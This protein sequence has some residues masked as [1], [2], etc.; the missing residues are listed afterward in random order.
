MEKKK[1]IMKGASKKSNGM[2]YDMQ[3][4]EEEMNEGKPKK[5]LGKF[6]K[7]F[8]KLKGK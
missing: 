4:E 5:G 8:K 7:K 3:E 2:H 1:G 6:S